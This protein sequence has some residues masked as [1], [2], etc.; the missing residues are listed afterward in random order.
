MADPEGPG[1]DAQP[2]LDAFRRACDRIASE[3]S[4]LPP[5]RRA[6]ALG[7]GAGAT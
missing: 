5:A 6:E 4:T 7:R 1:P 3:L 2:W